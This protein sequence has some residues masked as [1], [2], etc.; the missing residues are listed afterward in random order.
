MDKITVNPRYLGGIW[1]VITYPDMAT[2]EI[3]KMKQDNI[4][5]VKNIFSLIGM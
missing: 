4:V 1:S 3:R 2:L 5:N